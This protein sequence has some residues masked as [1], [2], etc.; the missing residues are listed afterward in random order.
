MLNAR[1]VTVWAF[2]EAWDHRSGSAAAGRPIGSETQ[3]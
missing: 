3:A 2:P 1:N